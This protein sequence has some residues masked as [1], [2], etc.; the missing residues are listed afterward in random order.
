MFRQ[1]LRK[2]GDSFILAV[3]ND[4][5][6]DSVWKKERSSRSVWRLWMALRYHRTF[7]WPLIVCGRGW[8]RVS[9]ISRIGIANHL[10]GCHD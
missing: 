3:P 1:Q 9:S 8:S 5:V 10:R 4:E 7:K 2:V 6:L